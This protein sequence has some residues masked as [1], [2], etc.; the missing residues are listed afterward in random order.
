M[1][2]FMDEQKRRSSH[3][4]CYFEFQKGRYHDA[5]W[6]PGSISIH[7]DAFDSLGLYD[8]IASVV[9]AFNYYGLTE[10]S[11]KD[12]D[13]IRCRA[14]SAGGEAEAAIMEADPWVQETFAQEQVFTIC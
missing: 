12:W 6:L 3:S 10:I 2:Y 4:S 13:S 14:R 1:K 5:C 11:P 8:L 9:P 7:A